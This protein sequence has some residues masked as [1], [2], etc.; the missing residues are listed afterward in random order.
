MVLSRGYVRVKLVL[1][2]EWS[3]EP[4][5]KSKSVSTDSDVLK[6]VF[7]AWYKKYFGFYKY[8][9]VEQVHSDW[10]LFLT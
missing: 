2:L 4:G 5:S 9:P 10:L 7:T 6:S 3:L 8:F 1:F